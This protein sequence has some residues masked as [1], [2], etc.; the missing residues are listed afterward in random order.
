MLDLSYSLRA[1]LVALVTTTC[2]ALV[3]LSPDLALP[4]CTKSSCWGTWPHWR[5]VSVRSSRSTGTGCCGCC[6]A[7][8]SPSCSL[9]RR[10]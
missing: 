4:T 6:G 10:G 3:V 7:S 9:S 1:T 5:S 8:S 2:V